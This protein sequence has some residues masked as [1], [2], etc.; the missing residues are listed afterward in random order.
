V[1]RSV[2]TTNTHRGRQLLG[3]VLVVGAAGLSLVYAADARKTGECPYYS[4]DNRSTKYSPLDRINKDNVSQLRVAWR[5]PQ[6]E[7]SL[8]AGN[9]GLR[10]S[11]RNTATPTL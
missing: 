7:P 9:S 8:L 11:N 1:N 4:A 5:L 2:T 6:V 3:L 10:L